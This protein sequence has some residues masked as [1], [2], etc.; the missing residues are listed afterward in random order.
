SWKIATN[1]GRDKG[2]TMENAGLFKIYSVLALIDTIVF[3]S[4]SIIYMFCGINHP[5]ILLISL[6]IAFVGF[7]VYVCTAGLSYLVAK[8]ATLQEDND[9][10]I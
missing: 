10:T 6:F 3:L 8:A 9:L 5:G 7:A 4:G 2:F 1:I